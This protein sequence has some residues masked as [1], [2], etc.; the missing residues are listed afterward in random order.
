ME[1]LIPASELPNLVP[2]TR[3][4]WAWHRHMGTGPVYTK[5]GKRLVYYRAEDLERWL[6]EN[7]YTRPDRPV[8]DDAAPEPAGTVRRD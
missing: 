7:R 2:G 5:V 3:Q 8:T 4:F 1:P 6:Q